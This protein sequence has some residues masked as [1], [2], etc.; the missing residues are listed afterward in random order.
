MHKLFVCAKLKKRWEILDCGCIY[1]FGWDT[2]QFVMLKNIPL[3]I[4]GSL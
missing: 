4:L 1:N 2:E 3:C